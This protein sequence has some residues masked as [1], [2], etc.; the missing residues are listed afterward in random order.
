MDYIA[1]DPASIAIIENS[2]EITYAELYRDVGRFIHAIRRFELGAGSVVALEWTTLHLHWLL[3]LSFE[4]ES[5]LT[6]TYAK[7]EAKLYGPF[8]TTVDM[9]LG[10]KK[11]LPNGAR[12]VHAI[13]Q[14]WVDSALAMAPMDNIQRPALSLDA[15]VIT[16][17]GSGMTSTGKRMIQTVRAHDFRIRMY[18][19]KAG[20]TA[21]SRFLLNHGFSVQFVYGNAAACLRQGGT[22]ITTTDSLCDA[23]TAFDVTHVPLLP[24]NLAM[25]LE[26]LPQDFVKPES[27]TVLAF[28]APMPATLRARALQVFA[29]VVSDNYGSN[30][31][32]SICAIDRDGVGTVLPGV[33]VEV[34][35]D[36]D[37]I[38]TDQPGQKRR[39]CRGLHRRSGNHGA[40]VQRGGGLSRRHWNHAR[41]P[42]PGI[43]WA[44][45]RPY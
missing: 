45:R 31:A 32:G 1:R 42:D 44:G 36:D 39:W 18:G 22:C 23:I 7:H 3:A 21:Q 5:I 19:A 9:A 2:R 38:L 6:F 13:T 4:S 8:L 25:A 26:T 40:H 29:T 16:Y 11:A 17:Y 35:D 20:F 10:D 28:G 14:G 34:V 24:G 12:R 37:Q 43:N 41:F 27:L 15:P 33:L 30:E